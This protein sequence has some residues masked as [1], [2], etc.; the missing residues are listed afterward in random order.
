VVV[1]QFNVKSV[2]PF[3]TEN[4]TPIGPHA[5]LPFTAQSAASLKICI[6]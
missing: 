2:S 1:D 3:K 4:D 6:S 5:S